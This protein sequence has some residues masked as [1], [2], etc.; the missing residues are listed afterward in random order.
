[1]SK[2]FDTCLSGLGRGLLFTAGLFRYLWSARP[3]KKKQQTWWARMALTDGHGAWRNLRC[4]CGSRLKFKRC[5]G[6][7]QQQK[8]YWAARHEEHLDRIRI[9][10]FIAAN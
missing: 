9:R 4:M 2:L 6:A 10:N 5:H 1:M 7:T 3:W 8:E